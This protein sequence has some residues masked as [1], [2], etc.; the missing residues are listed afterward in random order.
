LNESTVLVDAAGLEPNSII[1][2]VMRSD[3][4]LIASFVVSATGEIVIVAPL[5]VEVAAGSHSIFVEATAAS[6]SGLPP[7][8]IRVIA[9]IV[10][11]DNRLLAYGDDPRPEP[12]PT[13][14]P[15]A[16]SSPEIGRGGV[17]IVVDP[18]QT[19]IYIDERVSTSAISAGIGSAQTAL[20]APQTLS[21]GV[22]ATLILMLM[23]VML[24]YPIKLLQERIKRVYLALRNGL[25]GEVRQDEVVRIAGIRPDVILFLIV[26]Q[27]I[28][29]S[30]LLALIAL[31]GVHLLGI[32]PGI[33]VGLFMI[34]TFK[35]S[36]PQNYTAQGA[37]YAVLGAL[38][39]SLLSWFL[40]DLIYTV[41]SDTTS[42]I[43]VIADG[44][45]GF[46]VVAGSHGALMTLLDPGNEGVA[47][48]RRLH[49]WRWFLA[50]GAAATMTCA[51]L[52]GG[53][54]D[55]GLI[56]PPESLGEYLT[57]LG[58]V[59][60]MLVAITQVQ[61]RSERRRGARPH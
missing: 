22:V 7:Q 52:L 32:V 60:L 50:V 45:L 6:G 31:V 23:S 30:L 44:L 18:E 48:L 55:T 8:S 40:L 37:W 5:T 15:T 36:L 58:F 57:L 46:I 13:G 43:R 54:I 16:L 25:V 38:A 26:G 51:L 24:E 17:Q 3:P 35:A 56:T 1:R 10:D 34:R 9:L 49:L 12:V 47:L 14:S 2:V 41:E 53:S 28:V 33:I 39:L 20:V 29:P 61:R 59:A 11:A 42:T 27:V 19:T 21:T 4:I